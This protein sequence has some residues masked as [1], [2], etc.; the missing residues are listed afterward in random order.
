MSRGDAYS[1]LRTAI[2]ADRCSAVRA[3]IESMCAADAL[4]AKF[5]RATDTASNGYDEDH[6]V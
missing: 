5:C 1:V 3:E 4:A 2:D 6:A